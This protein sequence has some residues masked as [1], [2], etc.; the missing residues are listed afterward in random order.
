MSDKIFNQINEINP[1]NDQSP[2]STQEKNEIE[3]ANHQSNQSSKKLSIQAKIIMGIAIGIIIIAIIVI[4]VIVSTKKSDNS[5]GYYVSDE[6]CDSN[7]ICY[8]LVN[9]SVE[10]YIFVLSE[11]VDRTH[12]RY[13]NR[14]GIE[15][16][17]D[18]YT[19]KTLD[20]SKIYRA[21]VVGPPFGGVKEQGPGVY[22]NQLAQRNFVCLGFDPSFNGESGGEY[23]HVA[24]SDIFAEDF[25]AGV[26]Y[27]G[28]L[29]YVDRNNIG[30]IGICASGGFIL[31][32]ASIDKR[33]KAVVTSA[34][35]D[36]P[37]FGNEADNS[38]WQSTITNIAGQRLK[39]VDNGYPSYSPSYLADREYN[40]GH[41][42]PP[43]ENADPN[44]NEWNTFYATKRGHH[45]RST[46]GSTDTSQFSLANFP[47][48]YHIDK[49]SPRPILFITGDIAH[50][51][52]FSV[53][54]YNKA[55]EPKELYEVKGNCMHIDLYDDVSKIPFDKIQIFFDEN[56]K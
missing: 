46:G 56:L 26:D 4:I 12:V 8:R 50:S 17:G 53:N 29:K 54:T 11:N 35:Y 44:Y 47:V 45:P 23:R 25:S 14:Y 55:K 3:E 33:I 37:S 21:I 6:I 20:T 18:L 41:I 51:K 36:I 30:G 1:Q 32:A 19:P 40:I 48:T 2:T 10:H 22:C 49:I 42:P 39:D 5:S 16:A 24:S 9:P 52:Q 15:I 13:K 27:L 28:S 43:K 38:T 7:N 34:M 31:G